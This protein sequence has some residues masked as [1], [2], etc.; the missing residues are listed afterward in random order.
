MELVEVVQCRT[1][2]PAWTGT[3]SWVLSDWGLGPDLSVLALLS[4]WTI[5]VVG[6]KKNTLRHHEINQKS[7]NLINWTFASINALR[8][9]LNFYQFLSVFREI[10]WNSRCQ[11]KFT[12]AFKR[13]LNYK[14]IC[15]NLT[16][17]S[18][19]FTPVKMIFAKI[20]SFRTVF[21]RNKSPSIFPSLKSF[22]TL[23]T[24]CKIFKPNQLRWI[25][26][27]LELK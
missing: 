2:P 4:Q 13:I 9:V 23:S 22:I 24:G 19:E 27:G 11:S 21:R 12:A 5:A 17:I 16:L 25:I 14:I 6:V 10:Y 1:A 3:Q 26:L 18:N 15:F 8:R 7:I 20:W